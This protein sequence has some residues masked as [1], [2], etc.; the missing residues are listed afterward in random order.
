[1]LIVTGFGTYYVVN[2]TIYDELDFHLLQHK[3][4]IQQQLQED[5]ESLDEIRR[6]GGLGSYEWV[7]IHNFD[8]SI[9]LNS[10]NFST[11]D[12]VRYADVSELAESY[13][14]LTTTLSV[15]NDHYLLEIYEEVAAWDKISLTVMLSVLAALFIWV[16]LLYIVNQFAFGRILAPFYHTVDRLEHISSPSQ[17]GEPFPEP[18]TYEIRVLNNALNTM[19]TQIKSSFEDQRKFIQNASHELL[20]PLSIIRQKAEKLISDA[21]NLDHNNVER[22]HE[23]QQTAVRLTRLSNALLLISRVENRQFEMDDEINVLEVIEQ[24]LKELQDFIEIK[25]LTIEK[26]LDQKFVF[27]GNKELIHSAIYNMIQ[28]AIKYTPEES[29]IHL[30]LFKKSSGKTEFSVSD[31]GPGIP[32]ELINKVFD[33]FRKAEKLSE[34]GNSSPGLGLS[35]VKSICELHDLDYKAENNP[36]QGVTFS[37]LF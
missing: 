30:S 12:T 35:I 16:I 1:M 27:K 14:K 22:L 3:F 36:D 32:E 5:P 4:E 33:R 31:E 6:L 13:R 24:V 8:E 9:P 20:T 10:N 19:L 28:N 26:E 37:I 25:G 18:N 34:H 2:T 7:E 23:I 17:V 21:E 11:V 15:G 29:K